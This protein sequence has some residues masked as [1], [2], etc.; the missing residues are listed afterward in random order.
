[1]RM[2]INTTFLGAAFQNKSKNR[3]PP[4]PSAFYKNVL[5]SNYIE[6]CEWRINYIKIYNN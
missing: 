4:D 3:I 1:M 2:I 6:E 5:N